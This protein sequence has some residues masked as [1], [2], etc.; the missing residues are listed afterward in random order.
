[1]VYPIYQVGPAPQ[2]GSLLCFTGTSGLGTSLQTN[3]PNAGRPC[4]F[5]L[6]GRGRDLMGGTVVGCTHEKSWF[7]HVSPAK[8]V[9]E[10][11]KPAAHG[12]WFHD[13]LS[14]TMVGFNHE[15]GVAPSTSINFMGIHGIWIGTFTGI[16][17][18]RMATDLKVNINP[19]YV[20]GIEWDLTNLVSVTTSN[21]PDLGMNSQESM[22][23]GFTRGSRLNRP[24]TIRNLLDVAHGITGDNNHMSSGILKVGKLGCEIP[25]FCYIL[26]MLPHE[27]CAFC[28]SF[29]TSMAGGSRR[30]LIRLPR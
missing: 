18:K 7:H 23:F 25:Q 3:G 19:W 26:W 20:P 14:E 9:A 21:V 17:H 16:Y 30:A 22:L 10:P 1:M 27:K 28:G 8:M 24:A 6:L 11:I 5:R 15:V 12:G 29:D 4:C 2:V 13:I